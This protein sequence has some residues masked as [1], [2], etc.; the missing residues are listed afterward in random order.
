M[1]EDAT[2]A[3]ADGYPLAARWFEA[4][5]PRGVAVIAA[6]MGVRQDYY[7]HFAA[8]LARH[9]YGTLTFDYRGV[10]GSLRGPLRELQADVL[11][12]TRLDAGA[13]S[14]HSFYEN[15][16]RTMRR[17]DPREVG[18]ARIGHFGFFRAEHA[19]TLWRPELLARMES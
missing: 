13:E 15:A 5:P 16:P 12:W 3:A 17:I 1:S 4:A 7:S 18:L 19:E 6:A 11:D 8:W 2:L 9:G 14:I 10:G